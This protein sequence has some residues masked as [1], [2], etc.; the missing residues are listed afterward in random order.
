MRAMRAM[1]AMSVVP[2]VV[3]VSLAGAGAAH[4][5]KASDQ[6]AA[7]AAVLTEADVPDG[8]AGGPLEIQ[9]AGDDVPS[10]CSKAIAK[11]DALVEQ[12][13][14]AR[15][16]FQIPT[17]TAYI[18]SDVAVLASA[19]KAKKAMKAYRD[20]DAA[21]A[22]LGARF[23]EDLTQPGIETT[24]SLSAYAPELDDKGNAKV[25]EG[26]DELLGF[27]GAIQRTAGGPVQNFEVQTVLVREGRALAR[28]V[29]LAQGAIPQDEVQ[30]MIQTTVDNLAAI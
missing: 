2:L 6:R 20:E 16:G 9:D 7:E 28:L 17:A 8:F 14:R 25:I 23:T 30:Q 1:R 29:F 11:A 5:S 19:G 26:G 4:G 13:A 21:E 24:V 22:C 27:G 3:A 15:S 12:G 10:G 18:Q